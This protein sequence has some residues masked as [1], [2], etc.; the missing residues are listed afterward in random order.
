MQNMRAWTPVSL[1]G[2]FC[3]CWNLISHWNW[4]SKYSFTNTCEGWS[5]FPKA[6]LR[7]AEVDLYFKRKKSSA[8]WRKQ[9]RPQCLRSTESHVFWNIW[10]EIYISGI[11][12]GSLILTIVAALFFVTPSYLGWSWTKYAQHGI[13][14]KKSPIWKDA[15][16]HVRAPW[17]WT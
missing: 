4:Q 1:K 9:I 17:F 10:N 3:S 15:R 6:E 7:P 14:G 5:R 11:Q 2:S 12:S 8:V 13:S 16:L